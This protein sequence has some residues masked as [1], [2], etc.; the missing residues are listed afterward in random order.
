MRK[1]EY[2]CSGAETTSNARES[3]AAVAPDI[4][5]TKQTTAQTAS[6]AK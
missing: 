1:R 4:V 3:R 2:Q 5:Q 6:A